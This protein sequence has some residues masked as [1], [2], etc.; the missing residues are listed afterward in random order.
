MDNKHN[1]GVIFNLPKDTWDKLSDYKEISK[2]G[3]IVMSFEKIAPNGYTSTVTYQILPVLFSW[4][5][6]RNMTWSISSQA[7]C[8]LLICPT[9]QA[10]YVHEVPLH[11]VEP[12]QSFVARQLMNNL[13]ENGSECKHRPEYKQCMNIFRKLLVPQMRYSEQVE[14]N[15]DC[16]ALDLSDQE[17]WWLH[18]NG[19]VYLELSLDKS[20]E[21]KVPFNMH[22]ARVRVANLYTRKK[23]ESGMTP[24]P[25]LTRPRQTRNLTQVQTARQNLNN[26]TVEDIAKSLLEIRKS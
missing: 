14:R 23:C 7:H 12:V 13:Q 4:L 6:Q 3:A 24:S 16:M 17:Y 18:S 11:R 5:N 10:M 21:F 19:T 8:R 20:Y 15:G 22:Q 9:S 25:T 1:S 26:Y 2:P